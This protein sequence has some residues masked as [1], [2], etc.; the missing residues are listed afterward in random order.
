[1]TLTA[2]KIEL[3]MKCPGA[4]T[5]PQSK[6]R[7]EWS[8]AGVERHSEDEESIGRG[9]IPSILAET[10]PGYDWRA[11]VAFAY[12]VSTGEAREIGQG[13]NRA[14]GDL[15]PFE[16]AG[17]ADAVGRS[18]DRLVVV[19]KKSYDEVTR[20]AQNPQVRF[21]AL[22]ASL[23]YK[24]V[25]VEVATTHLIRGIDR[26]DLDAFDLDETALLVR[27]VILEVAKA[28]QYANDELPVA[29]NTGRHCRWC[30]SFHACPKQRELVALVKTDA[31]SHRI[32]TSIP[33]NDDDSAADAYELSKRLRMLLKRV[34]AALYARAGERPIP[35]GDGKMFGPVEKLGQTKID[36]DIA[37]AVLKEQHGQ[38]VADAAVTRKATQKG[39]EDALKFV[40]A[41]GQVAELKRKAMD[42]IREA[43]G[44][45][46]EMKIEIGEYVVQPQL[47]TVP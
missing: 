35:L 15:G 20:A 19:D 6:E 14:Y 34:D 31:M 36:G 22:A 39:I 5:L 37:Y 26:A 1:M 9:D 12:D 3:A 2:S 8:D 11:E 7:N 18:G 16:I 46:R 30:S 40:G 27:R 17:T 38:A 10:W 41:R 29:F 42:A 44:T 23:V 28:K 13:I 21:L 32:E 47:K 25:A 24:P 45:S 4:F 33:F 43:G